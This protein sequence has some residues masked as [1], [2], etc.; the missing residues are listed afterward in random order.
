MSHL[1]ASTVGL[2]VRDITSI[3]YLKKAT[4]ISGRVPKNF[5]ILLESVRFLDFSSFFFFYS[6]RVKGNGYGLQ[7][8][9]ASY[10]LN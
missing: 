2:L 6:E 9:A 3:P 5:K 8:L 7:D 1:Y 4:D 10:A